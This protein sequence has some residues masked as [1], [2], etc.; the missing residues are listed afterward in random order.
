MFSFDSFYDRRI[1][2]IRRTGPTPTYSIVNLNNLTMY[3]HDETVVALMAMVATTSIPHQFKGG[4]VVTLQEILKNIPA[5]LREGMLSWLVLEGEEVPSSLIIHTSM[6]MKDIAIFAE[7]RLRT[8]ALEEKPRGVLQLFSFFRSN[9]F[10]AVRKNFQDARELAQKS[11]L[12][13][14]EPVAS[15]LR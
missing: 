2:C 10:Q 9:K 4:K 14:S 6:T 11:T 3:A 12:A 7:F 5:R 13:N 15:Y 8:M 1:H